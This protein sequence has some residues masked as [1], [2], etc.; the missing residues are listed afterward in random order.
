M[1]KSRGIAAALLCTVLALGVSGCSPAEQPSASSNTNVPAS[2]TS[3]AT[4]G[5]S[6]TS[7]VVAEGAVLDTASMFT[8]RDL[9]QTVDITTATNYRV[10]S[11][12]TITITEEG[13]YVI[14]GSATNAQIKVQADDSAKVQIVLNGVSITNDSTPAIYVVSADKVFVTTTDGSTNTLSVT[15]EFTVDGDTNTDAVI[16]S[17]DDLVLNGEGTLTINSSKN[18]V[19]SKDELKVTG[20]TLQITS[21]N[22]GLEAHDGIALAGGTITIDAQGDGIHAENDED[23]T[24]G[25]VYIADGTLNVIAAGQGI[26]A[27]T[28]TQ[29]DGGTISLSAKEGVESTYVQING[30]TIYVEATDDGLNATANSSLYDVVVEITGGETTIRMASG[31]TDGIDANGS[32]LISGGTVD[33]SCQSPFDFDLTGK[34]T[35]GTVIANGEQ[36]TEMTN[37]MMGGGMGGRGGMGDMG[38]RG[39]IGGP[40]TN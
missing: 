32:I 19:S 33:V 35:G 25:Y 30:G 34:I 20:G 10:S 7:A 27:T 9:T 39:N 17:K 3:T 12:Q 11:G 8:S 38:A 36:V 31:D 37:Q 40:A 24:V 1:L 28:A 14:S 5:T 29:I 15:N 4:P 23:T 6:N 13:T 22:H 18:A 16:F 26:Q 21:A 2:A